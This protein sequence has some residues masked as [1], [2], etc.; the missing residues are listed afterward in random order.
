MQGQKVLSKVGAESEK[1]IPCCIWVGWGPDEEGEISKAQRDER[2]R[3][4]QGLLVTGSSGDA[5]M[6]RGSSDTEN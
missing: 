1:L 3:C 4:W 5:K 2:A 6:D